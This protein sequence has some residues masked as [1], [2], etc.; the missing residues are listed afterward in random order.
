LLTLARPDQSRVARRST[1]QPQPALLGRLP[2]TE[3]ERTGDG[4][5]TDAEI[6]GRPDERAFHPVQV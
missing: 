1:P 3:A 5:P 6:S 4:R 2:G